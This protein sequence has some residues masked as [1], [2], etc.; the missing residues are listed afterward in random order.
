MYELEFTAELNAPTA[1]F[2]HK[3]PPVFRRRA[4]KFTGIQQVEVQ[5]LRAGPWESSEVVRK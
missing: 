2:V 3:S 4:L 1:Q 5:G